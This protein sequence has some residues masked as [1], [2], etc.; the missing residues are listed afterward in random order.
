MRKQVLVIAL[1]IITLTL[2]ATIWRV[3]KDASF[4]PHFG[5]LQHAIDSCGVGD[6]IYV[7]PGSYGSIEIKKQLTIFGVGYFIAE[8]AK[9]TLISFASTSHL[10]NITFSAGSDFSLMSG[11]EVGGNIYCTAAN[12]ITISGNKYGGISLTNS[13]YLIIKKNY[14]GGISG[15]NCLNTLIS[16]NIMGGINFD[17]KSN[18][19]LQNNYIS[20]R[21]ILFNSTLIN[22]ICT[23]HYYYSYGYYYNEITN[24]YIKNNI[25]RAN[26]STIDGN[27]QFTENGE[28]YPNA[29]IA[30][31]YKLSES[32][33][34]KGKGLGGVDCGPFGGDD[35]YCVSGLNYIP[36]IAK[37]SVPVKVTGSNGLAVKV[38]IK[39]SKP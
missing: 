6:T 9:D 17:I 27:T 35:P 14:G 12:N 4:L 15:V 2:N 34:A 21:I 18:I 24:S 39:S 10:E 13:N 19:Y 30:D 1:S 33:I 8:N 16:N 20:D 38:I 23:F 3:T 7:Y 31:N 36:T 32:S 25:N 29:L 37:M 26:W 28:I 22:N 5:N 11:L